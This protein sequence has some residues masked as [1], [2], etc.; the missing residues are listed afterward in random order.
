M[1][2]KEDKIDFKT[3]EEP[4]KSSPIELDRSPPVYL[5]EAVLMDTKQIPPSPNL[6][7][8]KRTITKDLFMMELQDGSMVVL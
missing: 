2:R 3:T 6:E 8:K 4:K 7:K 5:D 1:C